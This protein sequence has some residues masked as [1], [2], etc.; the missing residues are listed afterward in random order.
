[1]LYNLL[2]AGIALWIILDELLE[3]ITV[4][5]QNAA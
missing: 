5:G 4:Q 2:S 3:K 1:M